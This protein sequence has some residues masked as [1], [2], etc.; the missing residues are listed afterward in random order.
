MEKPEGCIVPGRERKV[1]KLVKSLYGLKQAPKQLHEKFD[2]VMLSNGFKI[3]ECDKCIYI[4][5]IESGY[6]ILCLYV[7]DILIVGS[8]E[9]LVK[10]TKGI[11]NSRFDT[12][13]M[14]LAD[15]I[16]GIKITRT[17][18][19]FVL[20]QSHYVDKILDRG[21]KRNRVERRQ[22]TLGRTQDDGPRPEDVDM[23]EAQ[24]PPVAAQAPPPQPPA[25]GQSSLAF[26]ER[27]ARAEASQHQ[28]TE[29]QGQILAYQHQILASLGPILATQSRLSTSHTQLQAEFS[30]FH[31][32]ANRAHQWSQDARTAFYRHQGF[33]DY[34]PSSSFMS[35]AHDPFEADFTMT[36]NLS[37]PSNAP[38]ARNDTEVGPS[39][40]VESSDDIV[41]LFGIDDAEDDGAD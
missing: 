37:P 26:E 29:S 1:Y 20:G 16:L 17:T 23:P 30:D 14:G 11:L 35:S 13:D 27:L 25:V 5:N 15:V 4:K 7:D 39:H 10:S 12:K 24:K 32:Q 33:S 2:K 3:N 38:P 18:D 34:P 21:K 40:T 28:I 31:Y 6:V 36:A 8:N 9:I 41:D 19:G 22:R